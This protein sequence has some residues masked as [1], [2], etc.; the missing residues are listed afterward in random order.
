MQQ[1]GVIGMAV[2]GKNLALNIKHNGFSVSVFNIT[3]E[4][5]DEVASKYAGENLLPTYSWEEFVMSLE[6]PRKIIMLIKAGKPVDE[7]IEHLK[8]FLDK[9]DILIDGG[10]SY[11]G[12][13]NRRHADLSKLSINYMGIGVSG[14]ELGALNGPSM[15]PGGDQSSY[16]ALAPM[17]EKVAAK[18]PEGMPCV[19]Y[20]GP[21]GSGHYVK[22]IHNGIEYGIMQL[23]CEIYD[24]LRKVM[25]WNNKQIADLFEVWDNG[26][27]QAYLI[28]IT[29]RVLRKKDDITGKDM[30]DVILNEAS[31]KGTG[32][33]MVED[34]I[35]LGAPVSVIAEA[36]FARFMSHLAIKERV[37]DSKPTSTKI[38]SSLVPAL[39]NALYLAQ[40]VSY[41]QGFQQLELASDAYNWNLKYSSIAQ[42]WEAGCIIR[43]KTLTDIRAAFD[44]NPQL[45]NLFLAPFFSTLRLSHL[46]DLR[47]I[48]AK[49]GEFGIPVPALSAALS[50]LESIFNSSLPANLLQAQRDYF[51]AHTYKRNDKTGIFHTEWYDEA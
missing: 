14:G 12:D 29:S 23:I 3:R 16:A 34:A 32:N 1:I 41:A 30:V 28:S 13:T 2:M 39:G 42:I 5:T 51:G 47:L 15:M 8:P 40:A 38:G 10:N 25:G 26:D 37:V 48:V 4:E 6:T 24:V 9:G 19:A 21:E 49:A 36:V 20:I 50:Y 7:T 31:Y 43:S 18:N 33:W 44:G 45:D 46:D 17:L 35:S 11:F 22:M 27:L